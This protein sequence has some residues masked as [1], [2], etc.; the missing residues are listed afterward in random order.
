MALEQYDDNSQWCCAVHKHNN[1]Q[2]SVGNGKKFPFFCIS[3]QD[4]KSFLYFDIFV[5]FHHLIKFVYLKCLNDAASEKRQEE[6]RCVI[7]A[8]MLCRVEFN[9]FFIKNGSFYCGK[10]QSFCFSKQ[11]IVISQGFAV[12][13]AV[14]ELVT[15]KQA[16]QQS[17]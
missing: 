10:I 9:S 1:C 8:T 12:V 7:A 14:A 2:K 6:I 17:E 5:C 15:A 16:E 11:C 13:G 3:G 4:L